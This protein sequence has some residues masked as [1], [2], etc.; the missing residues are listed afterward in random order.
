LDLTQLK[1]HK[2]ILGAHISLFEACVAN[3]VVTLDDVRNYLLRADAPHVCAERFVPRLATV[4]L[5][6][7]QGALRIVVQD[8]MFT[9]SDGNE[10]I[11]RAHLNGMEVTRISTYAGISCSNSYRNALALHLRMMPR[12]CA[13]DVVLRSF[14]CSPLALGTCRS[15]AFVN[16]IGWA[17][18]AAIGVNTSR[19]LSANPLRRCYEQH[20]SLRT[21]Q[22]DGR[23]GVP[24]FDSYLKFTKVFACNLLNDWA[25]FDAPGNR[26]PFCVPH[27]PVLVIDGTSF[28]KASRCVCS[29]SVMN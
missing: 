9:A 28:G 14:A 25:A 26:C 23:V 12:P 16:D 15:E 3:T 5:H 8:R 6:T 27:P 7:K 24:S 2:K 19:S 13:L 29:S 20:V 4:L 22:G 17:Y 18:V 10:S 1:R 11:V 21:H